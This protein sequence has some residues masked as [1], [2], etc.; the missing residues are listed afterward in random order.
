MANVKATSMFAALMF[1]CA[2]LGFSESEA[3][4]YLGSETLATESAVPVIEGEIDV[5]FGSTFSRA[6]SG[7]RGEWGDNWARTRRERSYRTYEW[8]LR[9]T[10]GVAPDTDVSLS[11]G[12]VDMKDNMEDHE[13]YGHGRGMDDLRVSVKRRIIWDEGLSV[14]YIPAL[15]IPTGRH[16]NIGRDRFGPA[17]NYWSFDQRLAMTQEMEELVLNADVGYSLPFGR[18]RRSWKREFGKHTLEHGEK[19]SERGIL[20]A[21]VGLVYV[22]SPVRPVLE[23]NYAH[24]WISRGN[25]SDLL[26]ATA[27]AVVPLDDFTRL[28][29]GYQHPVAGRNAV[30]ARKYMASVAY[31]F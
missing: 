31:A 12:W 11:T 10:M 17:Q 16:T 1:A 29:V 14:A 7:R 28:K 5:E 6:S 27:G 13:P 9:A 15:T 2:V 3:L 19:A 20:D 22:E 21:N 26:H 18:T 24:R 25:D 30:R 23:L 4:G 8:E